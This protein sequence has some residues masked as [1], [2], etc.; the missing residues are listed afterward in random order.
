MENR[1]VTKAKILDAATADS[2]TPDYTAEVDSCGIAGATAEDDHFW[3]IKV[4]GTSNWYLTVNGNMELQISFQMAVQFSLLEQRSRH[5]ILLSQKLQ[6]MFITK[7]KKI[8]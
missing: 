8:I 1:I 6:Y 5:R 3:G 2:A 7:E 4:N